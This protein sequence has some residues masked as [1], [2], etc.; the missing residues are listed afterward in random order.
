MVFRL[1]WEIA[2]TR[3][4]SCPRCRHAL[5]KMRQHPFR[6]VI[7]CGIAALLF[8]ALVLTAPFLSLTAYGQL[9]IV[10]IATGPFQLVAHG[11]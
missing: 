2:L 11:L 1:P 9:Q 4:M 7:A 5:W 6:F 8:Y 10:A 3:K